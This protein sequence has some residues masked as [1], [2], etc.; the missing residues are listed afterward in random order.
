VATVVLAALSSWCGGSR[1]LDTVIAQRLRH[2]PLLDI[3][4]F[5]ILRAE[6]AWAGSARR[7]AMGRVLVLLALVIPYLE[8]VLKQFPWT[9]GRADRLA[10]L[11]TGPR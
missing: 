7:L 9:R 5:Q 8:F 2:H 6:H 1:R 10:Q 3:Q 4:S 11:V